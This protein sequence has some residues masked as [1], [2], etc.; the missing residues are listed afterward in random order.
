MML[1]QVAG[2]GLDPHKHLGKHVADLL[3]TLQRLHEKYGLDMCGEGGEYESFVLD[4]PIFH[5]RIVL[6]DTECVLDEEDPSVGNLVIRSWQIVDKPEPL[7]A[8]PLDLL[9]EEVY[10]QSRLLL[11]DVPIVAPKERQRPG[12]PLL[13]LSLSVDNTGLGQS[14]LLLPSPSHSSG[15]ISAAVHCQLAEMIATLSLS[16]QRIGCVLEDITFVH[17]YLADMSLFAAANE[18][19]G[20]HFPS[21]NPPSR[22]CLQASLPAGKL[23]AMDVSFL[24]GSYAA[25]ASGN[26]NL[27]HIR[28]VLHVRSLSSWAPQCI[29]PYSQAN[30]L[31]DCLLQVAG[32]F[33]LFQ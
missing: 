30:M 15:D 21:R 1:M 18:A 22:S 10:A 19:Y 5:K 9:A 3:P 16:L 26:A 29:G 17:L 14:P 7:P 27:R 32:E 13:T 2:A 31:H 25:M 4:G 23:L 33:A 6:G 20:K 12:V 8:M 28:Q 24:R 11:M